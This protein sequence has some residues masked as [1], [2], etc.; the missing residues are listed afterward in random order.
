MEKIIRNCIEGINEMAGTI[1]AQAR[2]LEI[3]YEQLKKSKP[4]EDISGALALL[5]SSMR[6]IGAFAEG[7]TMY[8]DDITKARRAA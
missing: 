1:M 8:V 3:V 6:D 4:G 5:D 2:G 7:I